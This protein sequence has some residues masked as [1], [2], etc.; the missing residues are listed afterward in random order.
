MNKSNRLFKVY[1]LD[2]VLLQTHSLNE[3]PPELLE[4]IFYNVLKKSEKDYISLCNVSQYWRNILLNDKLQNLV[5]DKVKNVTKMVEY[6]YKTDINSLDYYKI[7]D[8]LDINLLDKVKSIEKSGYYVTDKC[9]IE[10]GK[11][12]KHTDSQQCS[13]CNIYFTYFCNLDEGFQDI[14]TC[15][16]CYECYCSRARYEHMCLCDNLYDLCIECCLDHHRKCVNCDIVN[17]IYNIEF[18][19]DMCNQSVCTS[20]TK[21]ESLIF[22]NCVTCENNDKWYC[23]VCH[24]LVH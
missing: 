19:C 16:S 23:N 9:H 13:H 1:C 15:A 3:F 20:C 5:N 11:S 14:F 6:V 17:S 4:L 21:K 2:E 22:E 7:I 24:K 10:T 12:N 8:L 18:T